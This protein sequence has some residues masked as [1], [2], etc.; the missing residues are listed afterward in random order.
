MTL[1][2]HIAVHSIYLHPIERFHVWLDSGLWQAVSALPSSHRIARTLRSVLELLES[3]IGG[4]CALLER[5]AA[6]GGDGVVD[7]A[8]AGACGSLAP[9]WRRNVANVTCDGPVTE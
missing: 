2:I 9:H 3:E 4:P 7:A 5:A 1:T 8:A 6:C